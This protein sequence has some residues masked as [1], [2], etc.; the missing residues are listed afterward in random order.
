MS[1]RSV[2]DHSAV[3]SGLEVILIGFIPC[4]RIPTA[5]IIRTGTSAEAMEFL[6]VVPRRTRVIGETLIAATA[7]MMA[8]S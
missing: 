1:A 2:T 3:R 4:E 8:I 6:S 7:S 5:E